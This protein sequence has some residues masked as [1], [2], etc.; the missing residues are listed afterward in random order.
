M[1]EFPE[2]A[3]EQ[4]NPHFMRLEE[5]LKSGRQ[6]DH[7]LN[8]W[9]VGIARAQSAILANQQAANQSLAALHRKVNELMTQSNSTQD[10]LNALT[11]EVTTDEQQIK[12]AVA[13]LQTQIS[14][15]Q[16][17]GVDVSGLK[18]AVAQLTVDAQADTA[19]TTPAAPASAPIA[20]PPVTGTVDT[21]GT[22]S[23][24]G[25]AGSVPAP[26]SPDTGATPSA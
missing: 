12:A 23:G 19:A 22:G 17:Q 25:D 3:F 13:A 26:A 10:E 18:A 8:S 7:V 2:Y 9:L 6:P 20:N 24:S 4:P 5:L 11:S 16:G 21:T 14:T 15:L 1:T